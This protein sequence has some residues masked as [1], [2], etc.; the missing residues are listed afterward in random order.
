MG[1]SV[2]AAGG[3]AVLFSGS[4]AVLEVLGFGR[5]L[6]LA[7][8]LGTRRD[9][10]TSVGVLVLGT[11]V[12]GVSRVVARVVAAL[13][14]KGGRNLQ[15]VVGLAVATVVM[16]LVVMVA[17][18]VVVAVVVVVVAVVVVVVAAVVVVVVAVVVG[19]SL[20][21]VLVVV[22]F[23]LGTAGASVVLGMRKALVACPGVVSWGVGDGSSGV[24]TG[25]AAVMGSTA[26]VVG[27]VTTVSV[28]R[29][30]AM[31]SP[32]SGSKSETGGQG[33]CETTADAFP[34]HHPKI[35]EQ[36]WLQARQKP[37]AVPV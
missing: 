33:R 17:S 23:Q 19:D 22:T 4:S 25:W 20:A 35:R 16:L 15:M 36:G 10:A 30:T 6:G 37:R 26:A 21:V 29:L 14:A 18:M 28:V 32:S 24:A 12:V 2:V 5:A 1:G 11:G 7:V 8:L 13:V 31:S 34:R 3:R 9:V 27:S